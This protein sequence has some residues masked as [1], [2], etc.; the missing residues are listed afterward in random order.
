MCQARDAGA[1][2]ALCEQAQRSLDIVHG[3]LLRGLCIEVGDGSWRLLLV[4]HHL[5]VDGVSWRILLEDLR[6]AYASRLQGLEPARVHKTASYQRWS[7]A[8]QAHA[9]QCG[10]ELA[11][12]Q[13]LAQVPAVLPCARPGANTLAWQSSVELRL[14]RERTEALISRVPAAYRTQINDILLAA[15]GRALCAWSGQQRILVDLEGHGREELSAGVDVS[16]TVGWFTSVFPV[17]LD[18]GTGPGDA[19]KRVKQSLREVPL[20]GLGH[21]VLKYLGTAQQRQAM[22]ALPRAS[23]VFNYLGQ[24]DASFDSAAQWLPAAEGSGMPADASAPLSHEFTINGRVYDGELVMTAA[25]STARHDTADVQ[26]W[27]GRYRQELE[28]L[29]DHCLSGARG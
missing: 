19:L 7:Q 11:F 6:S 28:G 29:I 4:A 21:G 15:L 14:D 9:A 22:Q 25:F 12:W 20:H 24:F 26:A 16:R 1:I 10:G 8:L 5:V 2:E 13:A 23:L 3:P 17:A 27:M 18:A